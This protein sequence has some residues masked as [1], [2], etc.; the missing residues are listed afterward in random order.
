MSP[1]D[2]RTDLDAL[3]AENA[4]LQDQLHR[5]VSDL[6]GRADLDVQVDL[7]AAEDRAMVT[8]APRAVA[9]LPPEA[10]AEVREVA[11]RLGLVQRDLRRIEQQLA[12]LLWRTGEAPAPL[13]ATD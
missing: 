9:T 11:E 7:D 13:A 12:R 2:T 4:R 10:A 5:L 6:H 3:R 8:L 1:D